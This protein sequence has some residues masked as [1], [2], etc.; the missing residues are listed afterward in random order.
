[1]R[2]HLRPWKIMLTLAA[3]ASCR[4]EPDP[5]AGSD[6]PAWFVTLRARLGPLPHRHV[7]LG[8]GAV[9][10]LSRQ[11]QIHGTAAYHLRQRKGFQHGASL[12]VGIR[13]LFD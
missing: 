7:E 6:E 9:Y 13:Y 2:T 3:L 5:D 1:M 8:P 12:Q 11:T 4:A 10:S